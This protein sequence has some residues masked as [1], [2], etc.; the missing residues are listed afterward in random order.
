MPIYMHS[1]VFR[2]PL[3]IYLFLIL[4]TGLFCWLFNAWR[5]G[6]FKRA[7]QG[8]RNRKR[9]DRIALFIIA[10]FTVAIALVAAAL[11]STLA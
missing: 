3:E 6:K 7:K 1:A 10:F 9:S 4:A 5:L 2:G 11:D 8:T